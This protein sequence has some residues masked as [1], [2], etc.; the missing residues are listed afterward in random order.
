MDQRNLA[1]IRYLRYQR[2]N[3]LTNEKVPWDQI[4][5]GYEYEKE[6]YI[7]LTDKDLEQDILQNNQTIA[8]ENFVDA[9]A[10]EL[11]YFNKPYYLVPTKGKEKGYVLLNQTLKE[12]QKIG[13][14]KVVIK[15]REYLAALVPYKNFLLLD[16]LRFSDEI[17]NVKEFDIPEEKNGNNKISKAEVDIAK[18]LVEMMSAKWQPEKYHNTYEQN[19][20]AWI[21]KKIKAGK[22]KTIKSKAHPKAIKPTKVIDFMELL[23]KS[24]N[25]AQSQSKTKK[26]K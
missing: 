18:K 13:I 3:D 25:A 12:T 7:L 24:V 4:V 10:L 15:T 2:I 8:I 20:K 14:A 11:V 6:K 9:N 5:K 23:K 16:L 17:R 22:S 19:L 1:K 21:D 26:V